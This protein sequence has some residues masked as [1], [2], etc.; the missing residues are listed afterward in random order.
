[1][2]ETSKESRYYISSLPP[3]AKRLGHA[4][5]A[6][7]GIENKLHWS[8]DTCFAEDDCRS[9]TDHGA[10][11]LAILRHAVLNILKANTSKVSLN[12]KRKRAAIDNV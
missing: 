5:R 6:H 3:D 4:I 2:E 11:N 7:W 9:R 8:L 10:E 1:M 12:R